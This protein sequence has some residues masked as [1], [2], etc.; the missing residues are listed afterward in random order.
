MRFDANGGREKTHEPNSFG[1]PVQSNQPLWAPMEI[2]GLTGYYAPERHSEDNDFIQAGNLYRLM[3]K[4]EKQR[5][6]ANIAAHL[7]QVSKDDI[8]ERSVA[9]FR[10]ADPE[11][12][13][14][15]AQAMA[16]TQDTSKRQTLRAL[17][18]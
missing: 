16:K 14:R 18:A 3:G 5:L 12:G 1:G 9:H 2:H 10:K 4:S 6:V 13:D 11:Y 8:I 7:S 15:V 17:S